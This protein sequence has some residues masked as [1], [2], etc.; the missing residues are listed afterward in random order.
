MLSYDLIEEVYM[1]KPP[2]FVT[3]GLLLE[4]CLRNSLYDLKQCP[5]TW[6]G[7]FSIVLQQFGMTWSEAS[8]SVFYRHSDQ[9]L[10]K[11]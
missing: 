3:W 5:R 7:R 6:F 1:E 11:L 9:D 8:H 2:R 10:S 4:G